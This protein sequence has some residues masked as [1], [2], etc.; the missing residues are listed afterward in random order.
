MKLLKRLL[1]ASS[2][3]LL[4][5]VSFNHVVRA[6]VSTLVTFNSTSD[7]TDKFNS[8]GSVQF[9]NTSTGGIGN[10][11]AINVP[12]STTDI[13][14]TKQGYSVAGQGDI[15]TFSA[16]FKIQANGGY[17]GLGFSNADTNTGDSQGQPLK[18]IGM[19]F[20]GGGGSFVNNRTYTDVSWPPDL[21]LGNWYKMIFKVTAKGSNTYD[22]NFQI[23]NSDADGTLSTMKTE[24][25][26]NGI[27]N[28]DLGSASIIHGFFAAAGSRMEKIDNFLIE[29][30]GGAG[31]VDENLPVVLTASPS[32]VMGTTAT[33][34]GNATDDQGAAI[35]DR[36]VCW[37]TSSSPTTSHTCTHDGTGEG[38]FSSSLTGLSGLTAY[39]VRAFATNS[40]GTSYGSE[41]SFTTSAAPTSTPTPAVTSENIQSQSSS[42][43]QSNV[44]NDQ[45]PIGS[46]E[47]FQID[48]GET[49]AIV[50][51]TPV[52]NIQSYFLTYSSDPKALEHGTEMSLS[53]NG[54]Q[55]IEVRSLSRNTTYYFKVRGQNG[56]MP[57]NWSNIYSAKTSS[58]LSMASIGSPIIQKVFKNEIKI[59]SSELESKKSNVCSYKVQAGDSLWTIAQ[60]KFTEGSKF[61][62]IKTL[63]NLS[64]DL[65]ST[66]QELKLPCGN[67]EVSADKA[68]NELTQE[69]TRLDVL[70]KDTSGG[71]LEGVTVTLHSKVQIS[72][73][74]K[75]GIAKFT[76]VEPGDHKVILAYKNYNGEQKLNVDGSKT[77][78][79][80]TLQVQMNNGFSSPLVIVVV[81]LLILTILY[82]LFIIL[83]KRKKKEPR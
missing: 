6:L 58:Q 25:N 81:T 5:F 24:K 15:Y 23:W 73:T 27:V 8:D 79:V 67:D 83:K 22:L 66:G 19:S 48:P 45:T 14:T 35:T 65:L 1:L 53:S 31:F 50:Y 72:K 82:L 7:L 43:S 40:Q 60:A 59:I 30:E 76:N 37:N 33:S 18:G 77:E 3:F 9:T 44:C 17:G 70:V 80:L 56:C 29:L 49:S 47:L 42:T 78:Q 62:E 39:Y 51:F 36:G 10:T 12:L 74:N 11:G 68:K 38:T 63:N 41:Y 13:W 61:V 52:S 28:S 4:L 69:G 32:A 55:K 57:G 16:Y 20:H 71:P 64:S 26:L 54:V 46:P 34:G 21:V 2:L 75:E